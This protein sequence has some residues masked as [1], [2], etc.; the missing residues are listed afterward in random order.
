MKWGIINE[1]TYSEPMHHAIDELLTEKMN[2]K[3]INPTVRFWH[4]KNTAV[5]MGRFQSYQDEVQ[6]KYI[7]ENDINVVRRITGGGAM[8]AEPG[9][10]ITYSL[11]LPKDQVTEDVEKSYKELDKWTRKKL[12]E[13]GL[14]V[15][16]EPLNDIMHKEGKIGGAAQLRKENAVLHHTMISYDLNIEEMLKT[17]RIGKEKISD[18]AIQSAEK[19]VTRIK[20]HID[21]PRDQIIDE[22]IQEFTKNKNYRERSLTNQ[23]KEKAR[24]KVKEKFSKDQWNKKI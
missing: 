16:H 22:L 19:R 5:P 9:N 20:D 10:V 1:G 21:Y 13:L 23:E 17:L 24:Q 8:F 14:K 15:E 2:K 7:Q 18:K 4:R 12:Q 6:T 3:E 11:Y